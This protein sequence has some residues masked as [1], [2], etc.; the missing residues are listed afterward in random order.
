MTKEGLRKIRKT[1]LFQVAQF[2]PAGYMDA[3]LAARILD[4]D[5]ETH[6]FLS[7]DTYIELRKAWLSTT[8]VVEPAKLLR[9]AAGKIIPQPHPRNLWPSWTDHFEALA[10]PTDAGIGDV[11]F[12]LHG[13]V[14]EWT[15]KN[16]GCGACDQERLNRRYP[17]ETK[18]L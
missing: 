4:R 6:I 7:N 16:V 15:R 10:T 13:D 17:F 3:V 8:P 1:S 14:L 2:R 9:D 5:T 18:T 11:V 12:R